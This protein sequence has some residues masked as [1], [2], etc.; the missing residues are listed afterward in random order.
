V[1]RNFNVDGTEEAKA[2]MYPNRIWQQSNDTRSEIASDFD[3]TGLT[4][5]SIDSYSQPA[6]TDQE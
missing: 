4:F 1:Y 5:A 3:A 2:E 6:E